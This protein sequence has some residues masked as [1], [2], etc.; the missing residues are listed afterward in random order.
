MNYVVATTKRWNQSKFGCLKPYY[1]WHLITS[2]D[3]YDLLDALNPRY[4]FFVHWSWIIPP[5]V[6]SRYECVGFHT[7][8]LPD[9]RGGSPVQNRIME[10]NYH[11]VIT[12]FR[13]SEKLDGGD[14]YLRENICL[15]GGGE[16]VF[17][18]T[19]DVVFG[20]MIPYIINHNPEPKPQS[21]EGYTSKRRT[22]RD[23]KL[24]TPMTLGKLLDTIRMLDADTYPPAFIQYGNLRIEFTRPSLKTGYLVADARITEVEQ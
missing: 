13:I 3:D 19:A 17:M 14:V 5:A 8:D 11:T 22:P 18:R 1:D 21:G 23:S 6:Y 15:N 10:E 7:A 16:E 20:D 12:A 4:V 9:G 2:P 24:V